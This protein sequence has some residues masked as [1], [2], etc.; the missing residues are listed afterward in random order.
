MQWN[1]VCIIAH[2]LQLHNSIL[3]LHVCVKLHN[4]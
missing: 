3:E 1:H 2:F 4:N